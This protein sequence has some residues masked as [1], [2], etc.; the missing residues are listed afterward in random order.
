MAVLVT[1]WGVRLTFNYMRK[2]GYKRGHEVKLSVFVCRL[3]SFF[4]PIVLTGR[5][6]LP[7]A[8]AAAANESCAVSAI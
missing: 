8:R 4:V 6:G 7:L 1:L 2:G 3:L 5:A